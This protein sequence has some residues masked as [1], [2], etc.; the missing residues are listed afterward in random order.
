MAKEPVIPHPNLPSHQNPHQ[1][2]P[3]KNPNQPT[4]TQNHQAKTQKQ[5]PNNKR[6]RRQHKPGNAFQSLVPGYD[7]SQPRRVLIVGLDDPLTD[8]IVSQIG[9]SKVAEGFDLGLQVGAVGRGGDEAESV[10]IVGRK[11]RRVGAGVEDK[12]ATVFSRGGFGVE[13][14]NDVHGLP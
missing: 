7:L 10:G 5:M 6:K 11:E 9:V 4:Q 3:P 12:V 13:V 1:P 14:G 8:P 2:P